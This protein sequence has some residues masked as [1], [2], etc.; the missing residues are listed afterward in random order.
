MRTLS[1]RNLSRAGLF[2]V[3]AAAVWACDKATLAPPAA[4]TRN[5][6]VTASSFPAESGKLYVCKYGSSASFD[7]S[8]SDN[9]GNVVKTFNPTVNDGEC[10]LIDDA[11][12][13]WPLFLA[14]VTE[15]PQPG[16]IQLD[17]IVV[18]TIILKNPPNSQKFTG[19]ST[20]MAHYGLEVGATFRFYNTALTPQLTLAKSSGSA[21]VSAGDPVSFTMTV[22]NSGTGTANGVTLADTLP[23]GSGINWSITTQ[24]AGNPCAIAGSPQV[25]SCNFGNLTTGAS[26]SVTVGSPTTTASCKVY[27]N[28]AYSAASNAAPVT[29]SASTTVDCPS[30]TI[31][32]SAA[33]GTVTAGS[34]I[35]FSITVNSNGPGTAKSVVLNDP[36]PTGAGLNW[37]T[38]TPDCSVTSNTLSCSF[39]DMASGTSK[40]VQV[41]SPTTGASCGTYDNTATASAANHG[42]VSASASVIVDCPSTPCPA[43]TFTYSFIN[44]SG[45][46]QI[47]YDQFPA[48]NDN[49]YGVNAVGWGT[50]GHKFSDLVGSDHA[51][52]Q[53]VDGNGVIKLQFNVDYISANASAPS[54][55]ASLGVNGGDG[56][57]LIGTATGISATTS[58]DR[59]LNGVNIPGLFNA[60]HVQQFGSVNLLVDSPPTDAAHTTYNISDPTLTGWD[61]HDTYYVTVSAA[62]LASIGFD[63]NTWKVEPSLTQLHNSPAKPCPPA[64]GACAVSATK[65]E[66]KDKQ[67]KITLTNS[68]STDSFLTEL[69]LNWPTANGKLMQVKLDGDVIY[70]NPDIAGG[71]ALLTL[72]QLVADQNKRKINHNS[73]D[74]LTLI[75]EKNADTDLSKYSSTVKFGTCILVILPK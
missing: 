57:M 49:S 47:K 65:Y 51:G 5:A 33:A 2:V 63:P 21:N 19:T 58:L 3:L 39:G 9:G 48:P 24:P 30:L 38:A 27:N 12:F 53:L 52:F 71:S 69:A 32:K 40:T 7:I 18:D 64:A 25:L 34:P 62:K 54:G 43:G 37:S 4:T 17:S 45:D 60:A 44:A 68:G 42:P 61:F 6:D 26:A 46:L 41:T 23:G 36:L 28:T 13:Q 50:H 20:V 8:V 14:T 31:T 22:T 15:Q 66:V 59:N 35:T 1:R 74:V 10:K 55:Y 72:A 73:S 56:K 29:A 67:V 16:V 75:F 11:R 70:D